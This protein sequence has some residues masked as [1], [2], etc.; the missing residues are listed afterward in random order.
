MKAEG[1]RKK[2]KDPQKE[3][4]GRERGW[5]VEIDGENGREREENGRIHWG[6][7]MSD[8]SYFTMGHS[9][10]VHRWYTVLM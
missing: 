2:E 8:C 9:K 6:L 5:R 3:V 1:N 4:E 7:P 10:I